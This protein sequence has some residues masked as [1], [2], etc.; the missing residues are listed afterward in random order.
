MRCFEGIGQ[1]VGLDEYNKQDPRLA[2]SLF[3]RMTQGKF[4][5]FHFPIPSRHFL[6]GGTTE[7]EISFYH[8]ISAR[9]LNRSKP[10]SKFLCPLNFLGSPARFF[11]A[12][13]TDAKEVLRISI[14][15]SQI[16]CFSSQLFPAPY[17][18]FLEGGTTEQEISFRRQI[19]SR[20]VDGSNHY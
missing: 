5:A 8:Q 2:R 18:H 6:E 10:L 7:Q 14:P 15:S 4:S 12:L 13:E 11:V 1:K 9:Y 16:L 17:R 3:S 19:P 20:Y